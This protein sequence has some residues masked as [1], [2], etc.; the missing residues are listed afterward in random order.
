M[1]IAHGNGPQVGLLALEAA[2]YTE[3]E[4]YPLD[5][6]DAETQG[7]IG[8]MIEQELGNLLPFERPFATL[9]TMIEVDPDDPAFSNPTKF[10]GPV[11]PKDDADRLAKEKGWVV[12]PTATSGGASCRHR[13]R[14]ASSNCSRSSGCSS[15]TRS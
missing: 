9:L 3:E 11:Y 1:V 4:D 2:A 5:V 13:N 6:M 14:S 12:K 7:S 8:Y 15:A 10:I